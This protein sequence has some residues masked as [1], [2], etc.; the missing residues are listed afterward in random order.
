MY[1]H[2]DLIVDDAVIQFAHVLLGEVC[3]I[4]DAAIVSQ[5]V[6]RRKIPLKSS[7]NNSMDFQHYWSHNRLMS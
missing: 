3:T 6:L 1:L 4:V 5:E 2:L 7:D